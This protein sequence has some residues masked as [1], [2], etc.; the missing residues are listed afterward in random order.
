VI[1]QETDLHN[2]GGYFSETHETQ[3]DKFIMTDLQQEEEIVRSFKFPVS[4]NG[5]ILPV[6][7]APVASGI[8]RINAAETAMEWGA[9]VTAGS[10]VAYTSSPEGVSLTAADAGSAVEYSRG[11]HAHLLPTVTIAKGGTGSTTAST[12]RTALGLG[13]A[14]VVDTGVTNGDV[15]LM[16]TTGYPAADGSQITNIIAAWAAITGKPS[17]VEVLDRDMSALD[18]VNTAT[19]TTLY[20]YAVPANTLGTD[21]A[22]RVTIKGDYLSDEI[23]TN[24]TI[25]LKVKFGATTLFADVSGTFLNDANRRVYSLDIILSAAD[26]TNAQQL[27]GTLLFDIGPADTGIGEINDG[28]LGRGG[29][30][31][32]T[33]AEDSTAAKTLDITI[34]HDAA[35]P[36]V[37]WRANMRMIELLP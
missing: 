22:L 25:T 19:E 5:S 32:G 2:Q 11:D 7:N 16:D 28:L 9:F 18:I 15:P 34:Q 37:S 12:A 27:N 13:T 20:S 17:V 26:A 4:Y 31:A 24:H 21:K 29:M 1:E 3:F 35:D 8:L 33:S 36:D 30:F 10:L 14:A 6:T 23:A